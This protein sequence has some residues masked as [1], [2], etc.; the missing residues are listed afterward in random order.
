MKKRFGVPKG[1]MMIMAVLVTAGFVGC[2]DD[3]PTFSGYLE[4]VYEN[5][6]N[7]SPEIRADKESGSDFFVVE[8]DIQNWTVSS[9]DSWITIDPATGSGDKTVTV[10]WGANTGAARTGTVRV[11]GNFVLNGVFG[12]NS[13]LVTIRQ[14][15]GDGTLPVGEIYFEDLGD[16]MTGTNIKKFGTSVGGWP[17]FAEFGAWRR[18]GEPSQ[19]GVVYAG[20]GSVR[21][22]GATWDAEGADFTAPYAYVNSSQTF[23][24]NKI[25]TGGNTNFTFEWV[26]QDT[27]R[28]EQ[29]ESGSYVPVTDPITAST[30]IL[31]VGFDGERYAKVDYTVG[32]VVGN[33]WTRVKAEFKVPAA[34]DEL[35]IKLYGYSGN[36]GLR[37]D[38]FTL[39]TGGD[40]ELINPGDTDPGDTEEITV[41]E[42]RDLYTGSDYTI[43]DEYSVKATVISN[44]DAATGGN[45]A[46]KKNIIISDGDSGIALRLADD[47]TPDNYYAAGDEVEIALKGLRL[48]TYEGLLQLNATQDAMVKTGET[49]TI[50]P[51]SITLPELLTGDY[52]SMLVEVTG[53]QFV[54]DALGKKL[55]DTSFG[56]GTSGHSSVAFEN[57]DGVSSSIF[58]SK[59]AAFFANDVPEGSG[60]IVGVPSVS[61]SP[62]PKIS[63]QPRT[64]A[65]LSDLTGDRFNEDVPRFG[66]S[67]ATVSVPYTG[68]T[69]SVGVTG[70]VI[71]TASITEGS[72]ASGPTPANGEG[73]G[74]ISLVFAENE[75]L[76]EPKE[77]TLVVSTE[78]DVQTKSY[79]VVFTQEV[80]PSAGTFEAVW[81]MTGR[82][83]VWAN[84]MAPTSLTAGS[85]VV[86]GNLT[87]TGFGDN[88]TP[89][90][91]TWGGTHFN[92]NTD[93]SDPQAYASV[94]VTAPA[95]STLS[96]S[97][98]SG[99]M[100]RTKA[101]PTKTM[102]QYQI[103]VGAFQNAVDWDL[104][105]ATNV[106]NE[107]DFDLSAVAE[108]QGVAAGTVVTLRLVP[109]A[110]SSTGNWYLNGSADGNV[111][112]LVIEGAVN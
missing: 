87:P 89:A 86:I 64:A 48:S 55:N 76:T 79:E 81:N 33:G 38:E 17:S 35:Y 20:T 43:P 4:L 21:N 51:K 71:W 47:P 56:I 8:S 2:K 102:L 12:A 32:E 100:R 44:A 88:G 7:N 15:A 110:P 69:F 26:M 104:P 40:G 62:E 10:S 54:D 5:Q 6:I 16:F 70:N 101:G 42:L 83:N 18:D 97:A 103:G 24:I 82:Q 31:D 67:T 50:T 19:A 39:S 106:G 84:E 107:V 90:A 95:G 57:A 112:G 37:I 96:L 34:T 29:D 13:R 9:P 3:E 14:A 27:N 68:G 98:I 65:D 36:Q 46:S 61:G 66:V 58:V 52:E 41:A 80:V 85:S 30:V 109:Y 92:V 77:V 22:S 72:V 78:A 93:V 63:L 11:S 99:N 91:N 74:T 49:N 25:A 1:L 60:K 53:V 105:V 75:S 111:I 28:S 73:A 108:L 59:Y 23:L 94:T 45:S